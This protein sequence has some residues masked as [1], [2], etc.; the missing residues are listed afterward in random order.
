[1]RK[2]LIPIFEGINYRLLQE[3]MNVGYLPNFKRLSKEGNLDKLQC[4]R[5]PYEPA[6]LVSAFSGMRDREHGILAYF[7]VHNEDYM[8]V[9]WKSDQLKE[10]FFWNFNE[11]KDYKIG[12]INVFGTDPVYP[13]NGIMVSYA[14]RKSLHYTYPSNLLYELSRKNALC[15]QDTAVIYNPDYTKDSFFHGVEKIED[16]RHRTC[17]EMLK[18][19]LDILIVNYTLI[20]RVSHFYF[21]E[22][23]QD[24]PLQEKAVF[25]AYVKCDKI[26]GDLLEEVY[27]KNADLLFFS[28]VGF[29]SH[30]TFVPVN[31]YLAEC[32]LFSY[33]T[34]AKMPAYARCTAFESVQGSNGVNINRKSFYQDGTV[35]DN[36]YD[37]V[38]KHT[39][40][41]LKKMPNPFCDQPMFASVLPGKSVYKGDQIPDILLQPYDWQYLFFGDT[42]WGNYI[43]RNCQTGWHRDV[44]AFGM[45]GP[46]VGKLRDG[47]YSV[48]DILPTIYS[49]LN[50]KINRNF[51][52]QSIIKGAPYDDKSANSSNVLSK[53]T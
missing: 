33:N 27:T 47:I 18:E 49:I 31:D 51:S 9:V 11:F 5:I 22:I 20:E 23:H 10:H 29:D 1:M 19:D 52:G 24:C 41:C 45:L 48:E 44:S 43:H 12:V 21:G 16:L 2:L 40:D 46:H 14:M 38:L 42:Y 4:T 17:K 15:V 50:M 3:W 32:G 6:G 39:I 8:P 13:I 28:E 37:Q 36:E 25:Q 34:D 7:H 30:K 26:L 53:T 35:S